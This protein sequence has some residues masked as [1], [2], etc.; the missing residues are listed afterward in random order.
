[1]WSCHTIEIGLESRSAQLTA[2]FSTL[3]AETEVAVE[4]LTDDALRETADRNDSPMLVS[5]QLDAYLQMRF[6]LLAKAAVCRKA[7]N[8]P[9]PDPLAESIG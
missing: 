1:V 9:L 8:K 4:V 7:M 2:R 6:I 3:E 5:V